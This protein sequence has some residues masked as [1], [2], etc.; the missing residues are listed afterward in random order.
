MLRPMI[1]AMVRA[2]ASMS[3]FTKF[4]VIG[5]LARW[6]CESPG[7]PAARAQAMKKTANF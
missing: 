6:A 3:A 7:T 1:V 2:T 4:S 5:S